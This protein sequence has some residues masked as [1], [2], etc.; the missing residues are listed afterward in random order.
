PVSFGIKEADRLIEEALAGKG[1]IAA[2]NQAVDEL[3]QE[4]QISSGNVGHSIYKNLMN[5]VSHMLPFVVAGGILI[6]LSFAIW[7]IYSFDP[8]SSQYNA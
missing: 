2:E 4:T 1:S 8:E 7:G 6:A 3:E 5:G